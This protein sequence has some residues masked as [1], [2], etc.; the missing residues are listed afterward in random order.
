M[1]RGELIKQRRLE[2]GLSQRKLG[3][4]ARISDAFICQIEKGDRS[5]SIEILI[6]L[7]KA[8]SLPIEKIIS[9]ELS[10]EKPQLDRIEEKLKIILDFIETKCPDL[11]PKYDIVINPSH[12]VDYKLIP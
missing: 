1:T 6:K 7:S 11:L 9:I 12:P 2:L 3:K 10:E 4:K 5:F 8:L